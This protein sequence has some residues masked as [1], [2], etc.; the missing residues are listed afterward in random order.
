[1]ITLGARSLANLSGVH[2]DLIRVIK[3]A[4]ILADPEQDFTIL[5]GVR[6]RQQMASNYGKGRT[7]AECIAKGVDPKYAQPKLAKVT[8]L[9]DPYK[10][11]H[12]VHADGL[13]HAVD[14]APWP[15]DWN[16]LDRFKAMGALIK[17][18]AHQEGVAI[19]Y[20]GDWASSKDWPH[21]ELAA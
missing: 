9:N 7:A 3:R 18:A 21:V 19:V 10:S 16:D 14:C 5:E 1:M 8:W 6:S 13:G 11:N 17:S 15:I 2:P 12:G 4:A 20:G